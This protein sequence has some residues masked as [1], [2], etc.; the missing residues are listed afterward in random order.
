MVGR[1]GR[2]PGT[3]SSLEVVNGH[4][5]VSFH[6]TLLI[7]RTTRSLCWTLAAAPIGA[8]ACAAFDPGLCTASIEPA[9]VVE[10]RDSL[11]SLPLAQDA[12]GVARD[13]GYV[14]SLR[15]AGFL[16]TEPAS[17][18]SRRA[19]DE[20]AGTYSIEINRAGYQPWLRADVRAE[21]GACHV[22]T[23]HIK[24]FLVPV[25]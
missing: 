23:Q 25:R 22:Q 24:A 3:P 2:R 14:D 5:G 18:Y 1:Q 21:R 17:M 13:G 15:P 8:M 20:R 10:I 9:G 4:L 19:A 12:R 6:M 16:N 7:S 11:T